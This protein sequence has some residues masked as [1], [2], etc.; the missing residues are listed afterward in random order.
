VTPAELH[1]WPLVLRQ[2]PENL[3]PEAS[4]AERARAARFRREEDAQRYLV[5]HRALRGILGRVTRAP[6]DFAVAEQGKPFLPAAPEVRFNLA[7]SGGMALVAVALEIDVGADIE[8]VRAMPDYAAVAGR[9]FPP[10]E[11]AALAAVPE[12]R[13]E[14]DFFR[15]WTRIEAVL[16]ARGVGLYGLGSEME[17]NWTITEI[18]VPAGYAAAVAAPR[19]GLPVTVHGFGDA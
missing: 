11:A 9:F 15:R 3:L 19:E 8:R 13:R 7:H 4:A 5:A 10:G 18:A 12:A 6:L 14:G 17:D 2:L 16:K 1:V